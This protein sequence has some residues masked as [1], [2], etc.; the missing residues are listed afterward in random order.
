MGR[1]GSDII[2]L[3]SIISQIASSPKIAQRLANGKDLLAAS[4]PFAIKAGKAIDK[5][6]VQVRD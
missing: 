5:F 6:S 1:A 3:L 2:A 4:V